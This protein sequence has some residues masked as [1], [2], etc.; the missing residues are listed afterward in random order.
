MTRLHTMHTRLRMAAL[1]GA[2]TIV[3]C[4]VASHAH[5]AAARQHATAAGADAPVEQHHAST[6]DLGTTD[7]R[8][9]VRVTLNHAVATV[10]DRIEL[11]LEARAA[12]AVRITWPDATAILN[13]FTMLATDDHEAILPPADENSLATRKLTRRVI[14]LEPFLPGEREIGS[15]PVRFTGVAGASCEIVTEPIRIEITTLLEGEPQ[16]PELRGMVEPK[17][18]PTAWWIWPAAGGTLLVL[19]GIG[20][21][22]WRS[23]SVKAPQELS[24]YAAAVKRMDEIEQTGSLA[25]GRLSEACAEMGDTVRTYIA[26]AMN[27]TPGHRTT[28]QLLADLGDAPSINMGHLSNL[29]SRLDEAGFAGKTIS[30]A[31]ANELRDGVRK[32][33]VGVQAARAAEEATAKGVA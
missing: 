30:V 22:A 15:F 33:I 28:E 18:E 14:V 23:R 24:P 4:S 7:G 32:L 26:G 1:L 13:G 16:E 10:A 21:L 29:L 11:T 19:A 12:D 5:P 20:V 2:A 8:C 27:L 3:A 17:P 25:Q 9:E 31:E 6:C